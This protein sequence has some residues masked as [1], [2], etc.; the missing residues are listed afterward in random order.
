MGAA[1]IKNVPLSFKAPSATKESYTRTM[2][3][4][5]HSLNIANVD[6]MEIYAKN[7]NAYLI[8]MASAVEMMGAE[9]NAQIIVVR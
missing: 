7:A 5:T 8:V 6:A 9:V 1:I 4:A 3:V 2:G